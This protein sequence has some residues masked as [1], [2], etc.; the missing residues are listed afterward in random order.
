MKHILTFEKYCDLVGPNGTST[1]KEPKVDSNI[2]GGLDGID[3]QG[4]HSS[5]GTE[6]W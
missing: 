4:W 5:N 1:G 2:Y 6:T 3:D